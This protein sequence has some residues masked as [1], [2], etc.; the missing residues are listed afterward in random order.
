[1]EA[2]GRII[3]GHRLL[4]RAVVEMGAAASADGDDDEPGLAMAVT[5]TP[6]TG[7]H[8]M[9]V[10]EAPGLEIQ[11]FAALQEIDAATRVRGARHV[12][13]AAVAGLQHG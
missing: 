5:A 6:L 7:R 9:Q 12:D 13:P 2:A 4:D 10:E 8:M 1:M 11:A 3:E